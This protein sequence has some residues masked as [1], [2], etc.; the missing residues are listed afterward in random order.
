MKG[1]F[2]CCQGR[3]KHSLTSLVFDAAF[4]FCLH[5]NKVHPLGVDSGRLGSTASSVSQFLFRC[6][7]G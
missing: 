3:K 4:D 6:S 7:Q 1:S 2:H 5:L